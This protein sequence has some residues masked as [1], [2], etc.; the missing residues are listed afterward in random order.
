MPESYREQSNKAKAVREG[1]ISPTPVGG[2]NRRA[3][4]VAI[5]VKVISKT[6][7]NKPWKKWR[8]YRNENEAN[9]ALKNLRIRYDFY[10]FR[11]APSTAK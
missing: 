7:P 10:E 6:N 11:I 3:R 9:M 2:K 4:P 8:F 1:I 5:E